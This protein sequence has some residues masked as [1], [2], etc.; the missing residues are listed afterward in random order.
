MFFC[1]IEQAPFFCRSLIKMMKGKLI[2]QKM[3]CLNRMLHYA[4][5]KEART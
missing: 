3:L 1:D 2:D 5:E 4:D